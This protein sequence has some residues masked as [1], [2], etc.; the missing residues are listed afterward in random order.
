MQEAELK[1]LYNKYVGLSVER[2]S[3]HMTYDDWYE[4]GYKASMGLRS[5]DQQKFDRI[6]KDKNWKPNDQ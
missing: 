1:E 4:Y 6:L 3:T 2:G 5:F